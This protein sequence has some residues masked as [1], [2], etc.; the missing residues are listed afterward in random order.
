MGSDKGVNING[1]SDKRVNIKRDNFNGA[2]DKGVN[3]KEGRMF[4]E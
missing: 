2:N 4:K 1:A 3:I